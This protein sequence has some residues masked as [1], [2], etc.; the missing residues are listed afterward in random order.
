VLAQI[1]SQAQTSRS[2][3]WNQIIMTTQ[4]SKVAWLGGYVDVHVLFSYPSFRL[5][6]KHNF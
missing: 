3:D 5:L 4:M 6:L 2:T 1:P